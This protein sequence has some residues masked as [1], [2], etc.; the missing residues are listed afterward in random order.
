MMFLSL[1][2]CTYV[3]IHGVLVDPFISISAD[4]WR[5]AGGIPVLGK[6]PFRGCLINMGQSI[7]GVNPRHPAQRV[8]LFHASAIVSSCL[9][10][11]HTTGLHLSTLHSF[12]NDY[13]LCDL[14]LDDDNHTSD[15]SNHRLL[16]SRCES[17]SYPCLRV[18][19]TFKLLQF[20]FNL[21]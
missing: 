4:G 19:S 2:M 9:S 12:S 15:T 3:G 17:T 13:S 11:Q 5:M 14:R 7:C 1:S 6:V 21:A 20:S 18:A 16:R 10:I 8:C